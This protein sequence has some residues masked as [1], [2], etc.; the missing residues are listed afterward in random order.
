[1]TNTKKSKKVNDLPI[2]EIISVLDRSGSVSSICD[3][4][5]GTYNTFL[6]S[7]R[8]LPGEVKMTTVLFDDQYDVLYEGIPLAEVPDL[9][10]K[11]FVPRGMTALYDAVGKTI[12]TV[13]ERYKKSGNKSHNTRFIM[14][15]LTDG[16]ENHSREY[17]GKNINDLIELKKKDDWDFVYLASDLRQYQDVAFMS[18]TTKMHFVANASADVNGSMN[19][20]SAYSAP[21]FMRK[22]VT[23]LRKMAYKLEIDNEDLLGPESNDNNKII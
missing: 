11:T 1:M 23:N 5:I 15:I 21:A 12:I 7:Q 4:A 2:V 20:D 14:V 18:V 19:I 16:A 10:E 9:D 8:E 13:S 22:S 3:E 6:K 17:S